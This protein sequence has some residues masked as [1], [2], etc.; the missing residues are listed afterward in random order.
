M[1]A[2]IQDYD[3]RS[4]HDYVIVEPPA[5][6][7]DIAQEHLRPVRVTATGAAQTVR[8]YADRNRLY[9]IAWG[10]D[11]VRLRVTDD[12]DHW[13]PIPLPEDAGAPTDLVRFR[14]ALVLLTEGG[15]FK[16][17]E[18]GAITPLARVTEKKSPFELRD[19][20]CAAPLAVFENEL[21]LGGQRDGSL[22]RFVGE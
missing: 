19:M 17:K 22:Y 16:L 3:G 9:W 8:W 1:Y 10:R 2:G 15:L 5:G 4:P 11:G 6:V 21:Y 14:D 20:L 18:D 13:T 12:G 7:M